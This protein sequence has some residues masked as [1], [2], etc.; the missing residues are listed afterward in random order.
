MQELFSKRYGTSGI[1][2]HSEL[3]IYTV[4]HTHVGNFTAYFIRYTVL[5]N[6]LILLPTFHVFD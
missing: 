2:P 1:L 5:G 3:C 4:K 6:A